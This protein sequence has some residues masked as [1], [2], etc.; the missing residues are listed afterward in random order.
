MAMKLMFSAPKAFYKRMKEG[1]QEPEVLS[2][3]SVLTF[4]VPSWL[5]YFLNGR[6]DDGDILDK[7]GK[8]SAVMFFVDIWDSG[9]DKNPMYHDEFMNAETI[10]FLGNNWE[11]IVEA[12]LYDCEFRIIDEAL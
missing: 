8:I 10:E 12:I 7:A 4:N 6:N 3:A 9:A 2:M 1:E 5:Y 11:P